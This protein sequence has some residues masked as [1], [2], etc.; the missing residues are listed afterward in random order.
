MFC[1]LADIEIRQR[2]ENKKGLEHALRAIL[3]AGGN[4]QSDWELTRALKIGDRAIGT[5]VLS[6]FYNKMRSA[7]APVELD[8]LWKQ[9]GIRRQNGRT[10]FDEAA[11]LGP[12]RRAIMHTN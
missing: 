6:E 2:T 10:E 7:P 5:A 1:L 8:A 3:K 11:A 4:I 9:L 12:I